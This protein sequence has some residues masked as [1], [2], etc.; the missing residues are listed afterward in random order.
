MIAIVTEM[1]EG[2]AIFASPYPIK[3]KDPPK[4]SGSCFVTIVC[5][6]GEEREIEVISPD[7]LESIQYLGKRIRAEP[8]AY[9]VYRIREV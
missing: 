5:D 8:T 1:I 7:L 4:E 6:N 3:K 9:D 2:R